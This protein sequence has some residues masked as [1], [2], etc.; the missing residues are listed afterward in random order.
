MRPCPKIYRG[1]EKTYQLIGLTLIPVLI[2]YCLDAY[3][4]MLE[5]RFRAGFNQAAAKI[6]EQ[7]FTRSDL[8]N[9]SPAGCQNQLLL[10]S[11]K[12]P[13]TWPVYLSLLVLSL[14]S[15]ELAT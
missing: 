14:V 9:L 12:S 11:Y 5:N 8:F 3:Y 10:K 6:A 7:T 15:Y 1:Y 4:L 13:S 2:C